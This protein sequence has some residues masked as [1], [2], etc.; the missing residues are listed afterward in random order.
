MQPASTWQEGHIPGK[1]QLGK[2]GLESSADTGRP[3][4]ASLSRTPWTIRVVGEGIG[5]LAAPRRRGTHAHAYRG[6]LP[7]FKLSRVEAAASSNRGLLCFCGMNHRIMIDLLASYAV[8]QFYSV[9][10]NGGICCRE[11][12][13]TELNS[14]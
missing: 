5:T 10:G 13:T 14:L 12:G 9:A 11:L 4:G 6:T 3:A 1:S 8:H 7:L 2:S